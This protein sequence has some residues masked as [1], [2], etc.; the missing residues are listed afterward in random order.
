MELD[1]FHK[2]LRKRTSPG[3]PCQKT[4]FSQIVD[5][6][7]FL[8]NFNV[9]SVSSVKKDVGAVTLKF[10]VG[11]VTSSNAQKDIAKFEY[12]SVTSNVRGPV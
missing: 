5:L 4:H 2:N 9:L 1:G 3:I 12:R 6:I 7:T 10:S 8:N 11:N